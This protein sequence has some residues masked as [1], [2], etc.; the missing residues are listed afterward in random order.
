MSPGRPFVVIREKIFP[1]GRLTD[2]L[3]RRDVNG[4]HIRPAYV[5]DVFENDG[6]GVSDAVAQLCYVLQHIN[7]EYFFE[8]LICENG[9][10]R[11]LIV[12]GGETGTNALFGTNESAV[13]ASGAPGGVEPGTII[14]D[15]DVIRRTVF[16]ARA[17]LRASLGIG[18][19][20]PLVDGAF[21][22]L[23]HAPHTDVLDRS[24]H[25]ACDVTL[26]MGKEKDA[27]GF[28]RFG[29][30][31]KVHMRSLHRD[32]SIRDDDRRADGVLG[33]A[34][35][36][37]ALK[38]STLVVTLASIDNGRVEYER[39]TADIEECIDDAFREG[40]FY[41]VPVTWFAHV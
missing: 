18:R 13:A 24:A 38:V 29:A 39:M 25:A 36:R 37:G 3:E 6:A 23:R 12:E 27:V 20:T 22:L 28:Q 14:D 10:F 26:D 40:W 5:T 1:A 19:L 2:D 16:N 41:V 35:I 17:A 32:A 9:R 34:M 15:A 21:R 33:I 11:Q 30:Y 4:Q 8:A 7:R 31:L